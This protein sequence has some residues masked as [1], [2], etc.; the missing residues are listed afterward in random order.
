MFSRQHN[1]RKEIIA[2]FEVNFSDNYGYILLY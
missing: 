1:L 2:N